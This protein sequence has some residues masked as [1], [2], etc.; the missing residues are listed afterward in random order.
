MEP[1]A[2]TLFVLSTFFCGCSL[3]VSFFKGKEEKRGGKKTHLGSRF[4]PFEAYRYRQRSSLRRIIR[5]ARSTRFERER[6]RER[7]GE[8]EIRP[9]SRRRARSSESISLLER[10][11]RGERGRERESLDSFYPPLFSIEFFVPFG[12][13][14]SRQKGQKREKNRQIWTQAREVGVGVEASGEKG[15]RTRD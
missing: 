1:N 10:Q 5:K 6:E 2:H 3:W 9:R 12:G 13:G 11:S 7:E 8:R 15:P 4:W 14:C